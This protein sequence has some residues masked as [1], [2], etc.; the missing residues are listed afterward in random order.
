M[1]AL[2]ESGYRGRIVP[3]HP[4]AKELLGLPVVASPDD[5]DT[6]PDLLLV[7]TPA[8]TVPAVLEQWAAAGAR[9]AVVLASGFAESGAAGR[10]L[11]AA[12]ARIARERGIR[13][14]GPNTSGILNVPL[15]L[16]LIGLRNVRPGRLALLVQSG[17]ITLQLVTEAT[18]RSGHGFSFVVG[19]GNETDVCFHEYLEYFAAEPQTRAV[20]LHVEGF[21]A[22]RQFLETARRLAARL[23][24]VL[25]KGARTDVGSAAARSHTGAV[26]GAYDVLQAGLRQAGVLEVT[27]TDELLHVGET[28]G[29]QPPIPP[30]RGIALLADGG[31][32][33]THA[34][35]ALHARNA[36]LATLSADTRTQL[37]ALL[38]PA[39]AVT[40]PVDLAGAGDRAPLVF[41]R[42]LNV[43][44]CDPAVGG[45]LVVGLFGGYAIRF[46]ESLL[47]E[48]IAAAHEM[49][50]IARAQGTALVVHSL[51]AAR[52]SDPLVAL[53]AADVPVV[54]SLDVACVC[55]AAA[56][57]RGVL[58]ERLR[59]HP[60]VWNTPVRKAPAAAPADP[61]RTARQE[62]RT[63]LL[64]PEARLLLE[65]AGAPLVNAVFCSTRDAAVRAAAGFAAS[66]AVR[67]V[68]P[69]AA[70]KT[71]AGGIVLGVQGDEGVAGAWDRV[72]ASVTQYARGTGVE[73][74]IRGVLISPMQAKPV[75]EL[76][77]GAVRDPQFGP[78]LTLG[79]GGIA[80][81][82]LR[83]VALRILPVNADEIVEMLDQ[84][85]IAPVLRG[86]RG[87]PGVAV[88]AVVRA[89]LALADTL[90]AH[91]EILEI[92]MNPLFAYADRCVALDA[93]AY[94]ALT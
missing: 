49:A 1:R 53:T 91:D 30:G 92:E 89:A 12:V 23:P 56:A 62:R 41:A 80:V 75:A 59:T 94:V 31:G 52:R 29:T 27:R 44:A 51:Y 72:M 40:N 18:T 83:D 45:V 88:D 15:G 35:D 79:A 63:V 24:I 85:R 76:I 32:H 14:V 22:G 87:R 26:A 34:I 68:S 42:A 10:A 65:A 67:I 33:A 66:V 7:C 36:P 77:A 55:I 43:L 9:A 16:N 28:I 3:V 25:L 71:E 6:P 50:A 38:G 84:L 19:A 58:L 11:E 90:L 64:E 39:A 47:A 20:L 93:R 57:Q 4:T 73:P 81:E 61:I 54:E 17:N 2:L 46:A 60:D 70:H 78:V 37:R 69:A 74:D 5:L 13:V 21:R 48:E 82:V 86:L 8:A